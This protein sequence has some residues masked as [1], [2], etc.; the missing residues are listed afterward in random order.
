[1]YRILILLFVSIYLLLSIVLIGQTNELYL[2][3]E[4]KSYQSNITIQYLIENNQLRITK[5]NYNNKK[6]LI[7]K[8]KLND[9][10]I[11]QL[12]EVIETLNIFK[13]DTLYER[14]ALDGLFWCIEVKYNTNR[15]KIIVENTIQPDLNFLFN[16]INKFINKREYYILLTY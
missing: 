1:M 15:I 4:E 8:K 13:L 16:E 3:I 14:Q 10:N 2:K 5:L 9:G 12:Y 11:G 6:K 7:Y